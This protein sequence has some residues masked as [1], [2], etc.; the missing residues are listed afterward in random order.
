MAAACLVASDGYVNPVGRTEQF[1]IVTDS[2]EGSG[3]HLP[4]VSLPMN[5]C[6]RRPLQ[7]SQHTH[8]NSR[9]DSESGMVVHTG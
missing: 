3:I 8:Q 4:V 7:H 6:L 2:Q 9:V 5:N 1:K